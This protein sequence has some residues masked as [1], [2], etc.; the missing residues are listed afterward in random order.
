MV[1]IRS[2]KEAI[3]KLLA[4]EIRDIISLLFIKYDEGTN[5]STVVVKHCDKRSFW[6]LL[7]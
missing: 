3:E 4:V 5:L 2:V 1:L 6:I 7:E